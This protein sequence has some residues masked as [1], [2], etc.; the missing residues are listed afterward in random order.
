MLIGIVTTMTVLTMVRLHFM[1]DF[2][3]MVDLMCK[4]MCIE[5]PPSN[6]PSQEPLES[7]EDSY[8]RTDALISSSITEGMYVHVSL[9]RNSTI[10]CLPFQNAVTVHH[11]FH[12]FY[13]ERLLLNIFFALQ[14]STHKCHLHLWL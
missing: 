4:I 12:V 14:A 1:C 7:Y 10:S 5:D 9:I 13:L 11:T 8:V 2:N 6:Q 3:T